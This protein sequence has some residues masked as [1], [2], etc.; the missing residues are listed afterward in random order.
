MYQYVTICINSIQSSIKDMKNSGNFN[1]IICLIL[2]NIFIN[3]SFVC[4]SSAHNKILEIQGV[5]KRK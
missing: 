1:N 3:Y 2:L 5:K 4:Q